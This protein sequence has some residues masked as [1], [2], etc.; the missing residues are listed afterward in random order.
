M[1]YLFK[2][3][4]FLVYFNYVLHT[5]TII[6]VHST[7]KWHVTHYIKYTKQNKHFKYSNTLF[8]IYNF[9]FLQCKILV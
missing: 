6:T 7:K 5:Q 8:F 4:K 9:I 2:C 3:K 1:I